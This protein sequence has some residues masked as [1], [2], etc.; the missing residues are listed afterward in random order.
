MAKETMNDMI[1]SLEP[2]VKAKLANLP[3]GVLGALQPDQLKKIIEI[4]QMQE[5]PEDAS[6]LARGWGALKSGLI[7]GVK[8][9]VLVGLFSGGTVLALDQ[10]GYKEAAGTKFS[11][12][13]QAIAEAK[14]LTA[15]D[16][17]TAVTDRAIKA[18]LFGF[19]LGGGFGAIG[20]HVTAE[21]AQEQQLW[22]ML[23][24]QAPMDLRAGNTYA[25]AAPEI[26]VPRGIPMQA[27]QAQ[28]PGIFNG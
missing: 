26:S 21:R 24:R 25:S 6:W 12:T 16:L 23:N 20:S 15:P 22:D 11:E 1:N 7:G 27:S 28:T 2:G 14:G 3:P 10:L 8:S 13:D 4:A 9:G 17:Q 18:S 5:R 19:A